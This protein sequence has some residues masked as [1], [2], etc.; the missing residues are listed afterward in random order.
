MQ[1]WEEDAHLGIQRPEAYLS[2]GMASSLDYHMSVTSFSRNKQ[3]VLE[4][5]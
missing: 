1:V 4:F 5:F 2:V 3:L